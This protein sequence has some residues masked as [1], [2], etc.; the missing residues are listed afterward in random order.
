MLETTVW[1]NL[2]Y[3]KFPVEISAEGVIDGKNIQWSRVLNSAKGRGGLASAKDLTQIA[4]THQ[5]RLRQGD[6]TLTLPIISYY[7]TDRLWS[8]LKK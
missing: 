3:W 8:A 1:V 2:L 7:S 4:N 6:T 5:S